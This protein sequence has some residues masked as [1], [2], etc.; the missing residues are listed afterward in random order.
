M[1]EVTPQS[2]WTGRVLTCRHCQRSFR[3]EAGDKL[4]PMSFK[5]KIRLTPRFELPCSH[6]YPVF[7][8]KPSLP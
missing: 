2:P 3:I 6:F 5:G 8:T 7:G 4:L 1:T